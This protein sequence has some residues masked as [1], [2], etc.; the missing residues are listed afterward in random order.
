MKN[1][2]FTQSRMLKY[3]LLLF[4]A[5]LFSN[6][7]LNAQ[8]PDCEIS[9]DMGL[10]YTSIIK[11]VVDLG[12][13]NYTITIAI[14][15]DGC[16]GPGC[17]NVSF[18]AL[19]GDP[20]S[21]SNVSAIA[22]VGGDVFSPGVNLGPSQGGV[23]FQGMKIS[24]LG[25]FGKVN[26]A[27]VQIT[28]TL[29]GGFQNQQ[30]MVKAGNK[31]VFASLGAADFQS[32]LDCNASN[33]FPYYP[34]P[35]GGKAGNDCVIL[36]PELCSFYETFINLGAVVTDDIFQTDGVDVLIVVEAVDGQLNQL[37]T[38]LTSAIYGMSNAVIS[39]EENTV[40]GDMPI[41]NLLLINDLVGIAQEARPVYPPETSSGIVTSQGDV[42]M[43]AD[44]ARLAFGVGG[45]GVKVGVL[46]D[47]YNTKVGDPANDDVVKGDL[48]GIGIDALGNPVPN[49]QNDT[50]VDVLDDYPA[51]LSDEGRAM[52]QIVHDVAPQADLAFHTGFR[53]DVDFAQGILDLAAAG[54]DIII[55][56][57][58]YIEEPFFRD[59]LVAQAV[60]TVSAAGV[61]Y[62]SAAGNF[63]TRGYLSLFNGVP[64]PTGLTGQ[65]HNFAGPAGTDIYQ[66]I[67]VPEGSYTVVL[68]YDDGQ[69]YGSAVADI[70]IYLARDDGSPLF[71][72]NR[73]NIGG[74]QLEVLPFNVGA[75]G[76]TTNIIIVNASSTPGVTIQYVV[77]R[78]LLTQNEWANTDAPTLV[79]QANSESAIAVG[80]V[81]F[82]NTPPF[83]VDPPTPASFSSRGGTPVNGILREKPDIMGPNGVNTTVDLGGVNIDGDAFPNF[84][85]T[86]AAAPHIA[87]IGALLTEA[88]KVFYP[89]TT[90]TPA[91]MKTIL[92]STARDMGAP[93]YDVINGYGFA[94]ADAA[95]ASLANPTPLV[96][97][98]IF[99]ENLTPGLDPVEIT[100]FGEYLT[101]ESIVYIDGEPAGGST[102][103]SP[104]GT[105]ITTT[106]DPFGPLVNQEVQVG[107]PSTTPSGLDGGLSDPLYFTD[108]PSV[109]ITIAEKS[110]VYGEELPEFTAE[111]IEVVQL[112]GTTIPLESSSLSA[113][114]VARI[115]NI[116]FE[117]PNVSALTNSGLW[118]I[119]AVT[120]DPLNPLSTVYAADPLDVSLL[121]QYNFA[122]FDGLLT[123]ENL[124]MTI[125]PQEKT[126]TFG[127]EIG[128]FQFDYG[129]N[130]DP[131]NPLNI[132]PDI[133]SAI[134]SAV[135]TAHATVLVNARATALV[136]A[137]ATALVNYSFLISA[138][139]LVNSNDDVYDLQ[140]SNAAATALVNGT[141]TPLVNGT[142]TATVLVNGVSRATVLVNA[143]A[144]VNGTATVL[145]NGTATPL[146]NATALV[147]ANATALVNSSTINANSNSQ[148][149]VILGEEDID[150]LLGNE[151]GDIVLKSLNLVPSTEVGSHWVLPGSLI[152]PNL[153]ITY[154]V[155]GPLNVLP[156]PAEVTF[157]PVSLSQVYDGTAKAA[158]ATTTP[159]GLTLD[160][161]YNGGSDLPV[162]AG[163][164]A[165]TATINEQNY[166][167]SASELFVID[168]ATLTVSAEDQTKTY[169]EADPQLTYTLTSGVLYGED[170]FSGNPVRALGEDVG[171]YV[172]SQG[173]LTVGT[174]YEL[175]F[176]DGLLTIDPA[177]LTVLLDPDEYVIFEGDPIPAYTYAYSGFVNG[178]DPSVLTILDPLYSPN[179]NG[180]AGIYDVFPNVST[181][182][183]TV[184]TFPGTLYVNPSGGGTKHIIP[185]VICVDALP[186][187]TYIA[188]FE[189]KNNNNAPVF[190]PIGPDNYFVSA[191]G[192][193]SVTNPPPTQPELFLQ[194]VHTFDVIFDG[195]D[196]GWTVAS[197]NHKGQLAAQGAFASSTSPS[198]NK[199]S[200][201]EPGDEALQAGAII[202]YPNPTSDRIYVDLKGID[203]SVEHVSVF[204]IRGNIISVDGIKSSGK[205]MEIDLSGK[206]NGIY[207]LRINIG[208]SVEIIRI[209]KQ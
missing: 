27:E 108:K 157:D 198:C 82:S 147:N 32:V 101:D 67:D 207:F 58:T 56:D 43:R 49:P 120:T 84:F 64:A 9:V 7:S 209:V 154:D 133:E 78:G 173:S 100:I 148:A 160:Y 145:V 18:I 136:N 131:A 179:F 171:G 186:D 107:N 181:S 206:Q 28:Y 123:I 12:G 42:S 121:E 169:G 161:L 155:G 1:K 72:F 115:Q 3:F 195:I 61:S 140:L 98:L 33:I 41:V 77:F 178:D 190:I 95:L 40:T 73:D 126:I 135:S 134:T 111:S 86:S 166:V 34:P 151:P 2:T 183:Y 92:Q 13:E 23:P 185:K 96:Y 128:N 138:T 202:A 205:L 76:A 53:S 62:F 137:T 74:R 80:A 21:Y 182:N 124:E 81:L 93:G 156:A 79:G 6:F 57:I 175:T 159:E 89:G 164:Y 139:A 51:T 94:E 88:Q 189:Y 163:S 162:D 149:I 29:S 102:T 153:N 20:G 69:P 119:K 63:G 24:G 39:I 127:D 129:F 14:F 199:S 11:E 158:M 36:G 113:E 54:C 184:S 105:S 174:N 201:V 44:L 112:D 17:K 70:D 168:P 85:G 204:D 15:F 37:A 180:N 19:E 191:S 66:S 188:T 192:L 170:V 52:L 144:L 167:G 116:E 75:G 150:V 118:A 117:A 152:Y 26:N 110:K 59:G 177:S 90:M 8:D 30:T 38:E 193:Y 60:E 196:L 55:D 25:N 16:P 4:S 45:E 203:V 5:F 106:I 200:A 46:S 22:Y 165:V 97:D 141:A 109:V 47:S 146:V 104:D 125:V 142:A 114:E 83:G 103:V 208:S 31:E 172:I 130:D 194:G 71:G 122:I 132:T 187:G 50:P 35:E 48:P 87:A 68:Q 176:I 99:D 143:T 65:A 197:Y 10:G 91:L